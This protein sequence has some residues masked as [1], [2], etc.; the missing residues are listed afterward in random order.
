MAG[1][2][3]H[4]RVEAE[5]GA[6]LVGALPGHLVE[7]RGRWFDPRGIQFRD[8]PGIVEDAGKLDGVLLPFVVIESQAG[9]AGDSVYLRQSQGIGHGKML[10]R[11][12]RE[13]ARILL[14]LL[15]FRLG[16]DYDPRTMTS[17]PVRHAAVAGEWYPAKPERLTSAVD[18][19]LNSVTTPL[20]GGTVHGLVAPHAGLM[21]S[22]PVAAW[23]YRALEGRDIDLVVLVGPSHR[24]GFDGVALWGRGLFETP[25]GPLTIASD[26]ADAL[27]RAT[28]VIR[29]DA[30]PHQLEHSL[31]MQLPFVRRLL[32]D[33][34]I[35]PLLMGYQD[36]E[37]ILELSGALGRTLRGHRAL[38]IASSDLSHYLDRRSA[39]AMDAR[40]I[41]C[42]ERFDAPSLLS[43]LQRDPSHACGG[44]PM[45]S[46][47]LACRELGATGARVLRY[48]D[49]GDVSGDTQA[50]VGYMAAAFGQFDEASC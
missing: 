1:G 4:D 26:V 11:I 50:V 14:D 19:Y 25:L 20:V 12:I 17:Q 21:Y 22:G 23:A 48:A 7:E 16:R 2:V 41:D 27:L 39:S 9:E 24:V 37:S 31:E 36:R 34:R 6:D 38:L 47:M 18:G 29:E 45:V 40:V 13:R 15:A 10:A 8:L 33:A 46:V 35:V 43:L 32:P 3:A 5:G 44:G 30:R 28:P 42:V 49:S